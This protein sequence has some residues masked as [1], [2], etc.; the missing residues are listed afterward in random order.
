MYNTKIVC[1]YHTPEVFLDTDTISEEEK[2]FIRDTIYRQEF[3]N[4]FEIDDYN[5]FQLN[6]VIHE[7][8]IRLKDCVEIKNCMI[9]LAGRFMRTDEEFG[10]M[11]LFSYDYMY[12]T[13]ICLCELF[14]NG[15]IEEN[16]LLNLHKVIF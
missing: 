9:K 14:E 15:K 1:T 5:D 12:L 16:S 8:Y 7:L 6:K 11:I 10:L 4:I 3:L 2:E 13:H